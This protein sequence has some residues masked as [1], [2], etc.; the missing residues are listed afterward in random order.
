MLSLDGGLVAGGGTLDNLS[1]LVIGAGTLGEGTLGDALT[2]EAAGI[3]QATSGTL[4]VVGGVTNRGQMTALTGVLRLAGTVAN[5]GGQIAGNG[6]PVLLAG[7]D[8]LGV[9]LAAT[10]A[11]VL[12]VS[13]AS[14]LDGR[15]DAVSC[16]SAAR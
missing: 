7:A 5:A 4:A 16:C 9:T 13:G 2:N 10:G 12:E 6:H 15:A 8:V 3:L 1:D 11:G 14:T